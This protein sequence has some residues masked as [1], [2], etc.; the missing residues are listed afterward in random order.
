MRGIQVV[1]VILLV[2]S[3]IAL[4]GVGYRVAM[5]S[6]N[7][8]GFD[9][10]V[11]CVVHGVTLIAGSAQVLARRSMRG[12]AAWLIVAGLVGL[13]VGILVDQLEILVQYDE[14]CERGMPPRPF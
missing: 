3:G 14:W 4:A 8:T 11:L 12:L 7:H 9:P 10:R 1:N 6:G 2:L 5:D 13:A